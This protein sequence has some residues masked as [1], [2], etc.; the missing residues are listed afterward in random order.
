MAIPSETAGDF[1]DGGQFRSSHLRSGGAAVRRFRGW[2]ELSEGIGRA[3]AGEIQRERRGRRGA[4]TP[5][6]PGGGGEAEDVGADLPPGRGIG[7]RTAALRRRAVGGDAGGVAEMGGVDAK[8]E[9]RGTG[10][11]GEAV[12]RDLS[13][14]EHYAAGSVHGSGR[15]DQRGMS[16]EPMHLLRPVPGQ[17]LPGQDSTGTARPS[18]GDTGFSRRGDSAEAVG[19]RRGCQHAHGAEPHVAGGFRAGWRSVG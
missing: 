8:V 18:G 1:V 13:H 10:G 16:V 19:F 2:E 7:R 6:V 4:A 9:W 12:P 14:R 3:F 11:G 5:A 15:A 17:A